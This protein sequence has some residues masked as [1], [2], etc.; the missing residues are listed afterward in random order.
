MTDVLL[1]DDDLGHRTVLRRFLET[2]DLRVVEAGNAREAL[3]YALACQPSA[4]LLDLGLPDR[5]GLD[6]L[7]E[8]RRLAPRARTVVLT[9]R[10]SAR[11]AVR[12]L[13]AGAVHYL[14]K[15]VDLEELLLVVRREL[16]RGRALESPGE[17]LSFGVSPAARELEQFLTR[18]SGVPQVPVLI[19]G[20]TGTGKE[21]LAR[22]LHRRSGLEG[23]FIAINCAAIPGELLES[24]IFGHEPGAFTGASGRRRG[25][26]ELAHGGTLFLDEIGDMPPNLQPKLLRFLDHHS[27]RRIG[28]EKEIVVSCRVV[29]ATHVDLEGAVERGTFRED[30]YYRLAVL[31]VVIPP[32]RQ[33]PEDVLFLAHRLLVGICQ[34][35][36]CPVPAVPPATEA[37]LQ[38]YPWPGNVRQ[39]RAA[40]LR[41]VVIA[42]GAPILPEHFQLPW[43]CCHCLRQRCTCAD[44]LSDEERLLREAWQRGGYSIAAVARLLNKPRHW[45]KYRLQKYG[46]L[47]QPVSTGV[48]SLSRERSES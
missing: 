40:L 34:E 43:V 27:L 36:G 11:D 14:V 15:P 47:S 7:E 38:A 3:D 16:A 20:E 23:P 41:A 5:D 46:L 26:A 45:V 25:L 1:V 42:G 13:Q 18:A 44:R 28:G 39:L 4:V 35:L 17:R 2:Q 30:L 33:R 19:V 21:I 6:I 37:F 10:D 8:L 12:A 32:L 9:A 22:E 48:Q 24:E 31:R 29:A